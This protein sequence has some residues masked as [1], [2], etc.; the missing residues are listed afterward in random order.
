MKLLLEGETD[1]DLMNNNKKY[2]RLSCEGLTYSQST[3][4]V[5]HNE[6]IGVILLGLVKVSNL[7]LFLFNFC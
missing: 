6:D 1:S 7:I 5:L 4:R 3:R 2:S